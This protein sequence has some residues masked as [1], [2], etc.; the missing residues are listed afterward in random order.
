VKL[1][2]RSQC[3]IAALLVVF[4]AL[5]SARGQAASATPD[6]F[7]AQL[8]SSPAGFYAFAGDIT[9]NGR[10]VV[11]ESNG[12][13]DTQNPNNADGNR[14]IFL[15]DY[16]QRRI[17]QLTNTKNVQ[18][19]AA[20]PTPTPTPTAT[21]TPTPGATPTPTP[22]PT[23]PD[24]SLVKIEISNN[25]PMISFEPAVVGGKRIYTIVFSSNA[26]D[27]RNFDGTDSDALFANANQE[28]WIYQLPEVDDVFDLSSGDEIPLTDLTAGVFRQITDTAP[29]RPLRT[30]TGLPDVIDDNRDAAI[31]DDGK[32]LAFIST[33][34]VVP[35]VGGV[36]GNADSNPELFFCR[37]S[38][39]PPTVGFSAGTNTYVQAT[40]TQ[41]DVVGPKTF[42]RF[43][44]NPSLSFNGNVVAFIS[45]ANLAAAKTNN[46]DGTA[47]DGHG[48]AEVYV[49][50]FNGSGLENVRQITKTKA[51]AAGTTN[52]GLTLNLLSAGRRLSRDGA[53]VAY[54]SRAEDPT[55]NSATNTSFL[56]V[57]VS[58]TSDSTFKQVG[59]RA[60]PDSL[61]GDVIHFPTFT[62]YDG[63][64]A[65]HTLVFASALNF[66]TDGT[67]PA[68]DQDSTGLNSVPSGSVRPN[69][70][71]ATQ[72]PVTSS[73]TFTRLTK[74]PILPFVA[75]IRPLAS[76]TYRRIT[77]TLG[78][79]ELGGGNSDN[80]NEVF[81]L[82]SPVVTTDSSAVLSFF[83]GA[84]N[85]GPFASAS[86]TAS[87][88]PTPTPS[89]GDPAG[90]APG[91]LSIVKSTVALASSDKNSVGGSETART[92]ILPV[93][94]NGVSVSVNGAAAGLYFVGDSPAEGINF[95][96]P[97][98]LSSGV[99]TVVVNDQRNN[100]GTVFRGFFQ[101][102]PAQPDIF[103][104]TN[105][106]GGIAM[107]C[108]VT[109]TA[110][111]GCVTGPF[112][113]TTADSS[114]TQV[115]TKLEIWV[116]GVR[117]ALAVE[118]KVSFVNGTTTTD[119][120]PTSVRP[121]T[122]MFG[123]DLITI[124][125]PASLAGTA[126]IDYKLIVTVTK[127]GPS[128]TSRPAATASQVTI[129]P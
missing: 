1:V 17:F 71:F 44:Q 107:V 66:K 106:A 118:T 126:P 112:Q 3:A 87:P 57:F 15:A 117:L 24:L 65:P 113:V 2:F 49:A 27:P 51:E 74:N 59:L 125:L 121:N 83:T 90:L 43:Q 115:P 68:A 8:T 100:N 92:P 42:P 48:N 32:T 11:F 18:K 30:T 28:I 124:T 73:N 16:A 21:P 23:P 36:G 58:R 75:G 76:N 31:S 81:Y 25:H 7:A 82:L 101:I 33:R 22:V 102:V 20:S 80:S 129:I 40:N 119:I 10:F 108:N 63:S 9:A 54:E 85:M 127:S 47:G 64:L 95:V 79:V 89:P 98:G 29:S 70:I 111:S 12:N 110:V 93:E 39:S 78:A 5:S 60:L 38:A 14:E 4:G 37:T 69:Q 122:N 99:A 88:T 109:N 94:L 84:S 116:T 120:V 53:F 96:M 114:G 52:A 6:P 62:D 123:T 105:D 41:D 55:A 104:S 45:T 13:L 72:V 97:V 86:P 50:D 77:F 35:A 67:F 56:A 128:F 26:P 19:P 46:D 91:E 34:N 103:T 61:I